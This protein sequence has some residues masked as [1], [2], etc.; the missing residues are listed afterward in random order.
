MLGLLVRRH[1]SAFPTA[2]VSLVRAVGTAVLRPGLPRL[3]FAALLW[4]AATLLVASLFWLLWIGHVRTL[5]SLTRAGGLR[6]G[7]FP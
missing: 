1:P 7:E 6:I 4:R 5:R 2:L 3:Q